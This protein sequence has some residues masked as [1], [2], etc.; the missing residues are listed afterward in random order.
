MLIK[1]HINLSIFPHFCVIFILETLEYFY[2][3]NFLTT[4]LYFLDEWHSCRILHIS[5][6][7]LSKVSLSG[8]ADYYKSLISDLVLKIES[9]S[10]IAPSTKVLM[11]YYLL[12]LAIFDNSRRN[13]HM[14]WFFW[15]S[16]VKTSYFLM[17]LSF[18]HLSL[19]ASRMF[20]VVV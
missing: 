10:V 13:L 7:H 1:D 19:K 20:K 14:C 5:L 11:G 2:F 3:W 6:K 12:R 9:E 17:F 8:F 15:A 4:A 18:I 16:F